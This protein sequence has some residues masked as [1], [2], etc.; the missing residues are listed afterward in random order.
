MSPIPRAKALKLASA[1]HEMG[2]EALRGRL[3]RNEAG[4]WM[5][6]YIEIESWLSRHAGLE[7][8]L[9]V[10]AIDD[11]AAPAYKRVCRTCGDE[12]EGPA[13]PRCET[14]RRRLRGR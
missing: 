9:A 6:G 4:R 14:V 8:V 2:A 1:A 10:A 11:A 3:E 13:C 5:V 7:I 12:F